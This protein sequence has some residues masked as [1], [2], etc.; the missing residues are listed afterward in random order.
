MRVLC[1]YDSSKEGHWLTKDWLMAPRL[2]IEYIGRKRPLTNWRCL[3][4]RRLVH[5][6]VSETRPCLDHHASPP[7]P[8]PYANQCPPPPTPLPLSNN[9]SSHIR[10]RPKT[11]CFVERKGEW[12]R[13]PFAAYQPNAFP[14]G[15]TGSPIQVSGIDRGFIR[16]LQ[17][18][19]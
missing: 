8:L 10:E 19:Y 3:S 6:C 5:F 4:F 12:N 9:Y 18:R 7:A 11:T 15:Q 1:S 13:G 17:C 2:S 16:I 14:L